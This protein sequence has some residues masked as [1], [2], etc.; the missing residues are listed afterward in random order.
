MINSAGIGDEG[1]EDEGSDGGEN[2]GAESLSIGVC[3]AGETG[4]IGDLCA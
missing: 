3:G 1:C 2:A 4:E